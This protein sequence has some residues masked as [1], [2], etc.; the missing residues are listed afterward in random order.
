MWLLYRPPNNS[1]TEYLGGWGRQLRFQFTSLECYNF[2]VNENQEPPRSHLD[3]ISET[4]RGPGRLPELT[5]LQ[6]QDPQ[7]FTSSPPT[8]DQLLAILE[9]ER[10]PVLGRDE[11]KVARDRVAE[12]EAAA[13]NDPELAEKVKTIYSALLEQELNRLLIEQ[14]DELRKIENYYDG[15]R[16]DPDE[17]KKALKRISTARDK[18]QKF[19]VRVRS[20]D[21][22]GRQEQTNKIISKLDNFLE[23]E[24]RPL[25]A[26]IKS[27]TAIGSQ[28][29]LQPE[30]TPLP[31]DVIDDSKKFKEDLEKEVTTFVE[32]QRNI[33]RNISSDLDYDP[34]EGSPSD[35][36]KFRDSFSYF[37]LILFPHF[38][39]R[40][41]TIGTD[42]LK[43]FYE[44]EKRVA[45]TSR[46][47]SEEIAARIKLIVFSRLPE[48]GDLENE[49]SSLESLPVNGKAGDNP[50]IQLETI[51]TR[52]QALK[53]Q[54]GSPNSLLVV[55]TTGDDSQE[56]RE[57][58]EQLL[59]KAESLVKNLTQELYDYYFVST[60][61]KI[62]TVNHLWQEL[63]K[64]SPTSQNELATRIRELEHWWGQ[65]WDDTNNQPRPDIVPEL[66]VAGNTIFPD[67]NL[68]DQ[69]NR[70]PVLQQTI[71]RYQ[72]AIE[73]FSSLEYQLKAQSLISLLDTIDRL[74]FTGSRV[75]D[76]TQVG[77]TGQQFT[78]QDLRSLAQDLE[79]GRTAHRV[80]LNA[81]GAKGDREINRINNSL[82]KIR[83]LIQEIENRPVEQMTLTEI[84]DELISGR[85]KANP[86]DWQYWRSVAENTSRS[87]ALVDAFHNRIFDKE[88]NLS[89]DYATEPE[90][91]KKE[92]ERQTQH[93]RVALA[94][95][96]Q[97]LQS[98][99]GKASGNRDKLIDSV[100]K[101]MQSNRASWLAATT[102]HSE[103]GENIR[104]V[105]R[106][107]YYTSAIQ[108]HESGYNPY[109]AYNSLASEQGQDNLAHAIEGEFPH[110]DSNLVSTVVSLFS[111]FSVLDSILREAK[112][113][114]KTTG[115][116]HASK[117]NRVLIQNP[118]AAYIHE[119]YRYGG[120]K[121]DWSAWW[122]AYLG[123]LP[124]GYGPYKEDGG[125]VLNQQGTPIQVGEQPVDQSADINEIRELILLFENCFYDTSEFEGKIYSTAELNRSNPD[126][127]MRH[128]FPDTFDMLM[129]GERETL[130]VPD[131]ANERWNVV[132]HEGKTVIY[133][134]RGEIFDAVTS[135][136]LATIQGD[137]VI[138]TNG[139]SLGHIK[140]VK[141]KNVSLEFDVPNNFE[142]Y[143]AAETG[144]ENGEAGWKKLLTFDFQELSGLTAEVI[145]GSV[146]QGKP[147]LLNQWLR[148]AGQVKMFPGN[149]LR[150]A[151]EPMLTRFIFRLFSNFQSTDPRERKNLYTDIVRELENSIESGGLASYNQEVRTVIKKLEGDRRYKGM[152]SNLRPWNESGE[153]QKARIKYM[154][155]YW[156]HTHPD[157]PNPPK[158]LER[159]AT[160]RDLTPEENRYLRILNGS[161]PVP[162][163]VNRSGDFFKPKDETK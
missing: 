115:H 23:N 79:R 9:D 47:T 110:L 160:V 13:L 162:K 87:K 71:R 98:E 28:P 125:V 83:S 32:L 97:T 34:R 107:V 111:N 50:T 100:Y 76:S 75:V 131:A 135:Q 46:V 143:E 85:A 96:P 25:E 121:K 163:P 134:K 120:N 64:P 93:H 74:K 65:F 29:G 37:Q 101:L 41:N 6:Q 3:R 42:E 51:Y 60:P 78:S 35:A 137:Q 103:H 88:Q 127:R 116:D 108:P 40:A 155:I 159:F 17:V 18:V 149:P 54:Q 20:R 10:T 21:P 24:L 139:T 66:V 114:T 43:L 145:M 39:E 84:A 156:R 92:Q 128:V 136:L 59:S 52:F 38:R 161:E 4:K 80:L 57:E 152:S 55:E 148:T 7:L 122:L 129:L 27:G 70:S 89:G 154:E 146:E 141:I 109:L 12:L 77:E 142:L 11:I 104:K 81:M 61:P 86:F 33:V 8:A 123:E 124:P 118:L 44:I 102:Y 91:I 150:K 72:S 22:Y 132:N 130:V 99:T 45:N 147:G 56:V 31:V 82:Q 140:K 49:I 112:L 1:T 106:W 151:I 126:N 26:K 67:G 117:V 157:G 5:H 63:N 53:S 36:S 19:R 48:L 113:N 95:L 14:Q 158:P 58:I 138:D 105:L 90:R 119:A 144:G 68:S 133:V 15:R 62:S 2:F 94:K 16:E 30:T 153:R 69:M 73:N